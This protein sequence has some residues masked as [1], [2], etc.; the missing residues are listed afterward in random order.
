MKRFLCLLLFPYCLAAQNL[1]DSITQKID[2]VFKSFSSSSP[3]CAI[4]VI[5]KGEV[6]FQKGYGMANLEYAIPIAPATAFH[7][8]SMSKQYVAFCMLLLEKEGKLSLDDDIR[9]HLDYMPDFGE[10]ITIR[11]LIHHTSGLRDQWSLLG[12][13]GFQ[14]DDVI[15][16]QHVIKLISKQNALNFKPGD[17]FS[18]C[19]TGYT[20][21]AEI[22]KKVSGLTLRQYT[23]KNIFQ[24][25]GMNNTHFHDNYQEIVPGRAYSYANKPLEGYQHAVL[26]Y[27]TVGATSL[28]TTILDEAKWF[29]N[30]ETGTVGGKDL[31]EKMYEAGVLNNGRKQN[32]AFG[33]VIDKFKG[34][35]RI[36]HNGADAG[37]RSNGAMYPENDLGIIIFSNLGSVNTTGLTEQVAN[38]FITTN[39]EESA[40][41][42]ND[43]F[44]DS[45]FHKRMQGNYY[46]ERGYSWDFIWRNGKLI[47]GGTEIKFL[48]GNNYRYPAN[49]DGMILIL[50]KKNA[51]S[52]S[53]ME[54]KMETP[55]STILFK[56][57]SLQ[58]QKPTAEFT[59]R[60]YNKETEAY[61]TIVEKDGKLTMQHRKY[62]DMP[63][64]YVAPDMFN[65]RQWFMG[66]IIFTRDAKGKITG[67]ESN[68][69]RV[70]HVR[71][72]KVN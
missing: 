72:D 66:N 35:K 31:V 62:D 33:L 8:A 57:Q 42:G 71:Y 52:D 2:R 4:A 16:Q 40:V 53:V 39:K 56:R 10:K 23:D 44:A 58:S 45:N 49:R 20:L 41:A 17:E 63:L 13:A 61:Y 21:M 47:R 15:T 1:P 27:G 19:N 22:V 32:Y 26:S 25:L 46:S 5:K 3:G 30:F 12:I 43:N 9:K 14:L 67:F 48:Q 7:I 24:P 64:V 6:I 68:A 55:G 18:Y 69:G 37:F 29:R 54:M 65:T 70:L 59:G 38:I 34:W 51:S 11:Q 50:D 28:F 60:F 36:G